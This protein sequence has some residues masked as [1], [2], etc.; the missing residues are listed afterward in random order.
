MRRAIMKYLPIILLLSVFL[1]FFGCQKSENNSSLAESISQADSFVSDPLDEST[2]A[3]NSQSENYQEDSSDYQGQN[4]QEGKDNSDTFQVSDFT[5]LSSFFPEK[6][7]AVLTT[8]KNL[9]VQSEQALWVVEGGEKRKVLELLPGVDSESLQIAESSTGYTTL[10]ISLTETDPVLALLPGF[11]D[12]SI[13]CN[14][15]DKSF[16]QVKQIDFKALANE[17]GISGNP[18]KA[19]L[20]QDGQE[21]AC[22]YGSIAA[23]ESIMFYDID[24][25][26]IAVVAVAEIN[27]GS[28]LCSID[29]CCLVRGTDET[30]L[31]FSGKCIFTTG[32]STPV[33][34][35]ITS[36]GTADI[37]QPNAIRGDL[38]SSETAKFNNYN[39]FI[40]EDTRYKDGRCL[41]VDILTMEEKSISFTEKGEGDLVYPSEDGHYLCTIAETADLYSYILRIYD[42]ENN[43]ACVL[44]E[45]I[46]Q[47][48]DAHVEILSKERICILVLYAK[49]SG[50]ETQILAWQF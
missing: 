21:I 4:S 1:C 7:N 35:R 31:V 11:A 37:Y 43:Q 46:S 6:I 28:N 42:M 5:G 20:S 12:G 50:T 8:R 41:Q 34:G 9:F 36:K 30:I 48:V 2:S 17:H 44:E 38:L 40:A 49:E 27:Q 22:V 47:P 39:L 13:V 26:N 24:S 32:S 33:Y 3:S 29:Q 19:V 25:G 18:L 14:V 23:P 16:N 45:T 15:L 10:Y